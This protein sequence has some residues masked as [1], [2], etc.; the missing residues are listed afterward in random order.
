I[1]RVIAGF[2][3]VAERARAGLGRED[4]GE[5][6]EQRGFAGAIRANEHDA[7]AALGLKIQAAIDH[8]I[9][10]S[11]VNPGESDDA[12]TAPLR[13]RELEINL[14]LVIDRRLHF[15]HALD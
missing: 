11:M 9:T 14:A 13:L 8:V 5:D 6:F 12:L 10:I 1:L 3:I 15:V 4:A 7:L 2:G